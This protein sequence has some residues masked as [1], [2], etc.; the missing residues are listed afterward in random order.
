MGS[1]ALAA[2]LG[3][4][5]GAVPSGVLATRLCGAPDV[6]RVGSGH[7]GGTNVVR[8][9]G[10]VW[11]GAA[12]AVL[13]IALAAAAVVLAGAF[14]QG[15]WPAALA[16]AAAVVG[17]NWSAYIGLRGGVGLSSIT[18]M[19]IA[20]GPLATLAALVCAVAIWISA[21]RLL[22]HDAR[23]TVVTIALVPLLLVLFGQPLPVVVSGILGAL[24]IIA[25]ALEDWRRPYR[26]GEAFAQQF[27]R[28]KDAPRPPNERP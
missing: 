23:S 25:R 28:R 20:Q 12:T 11:A 9:T 14:W 19:L 26:R 4:A 15:P 7:T 22:G 2:L 17:H 8:A 10:R 3:Y 16:G 27:L 13:D 21:R 5:L 18:G 6:R 24:A 1:L